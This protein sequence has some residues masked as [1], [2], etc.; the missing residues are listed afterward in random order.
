[1]NKIT[2][3]TSVRA[4]I[5]WVWIIK[6]KQTS[7]IQRVTQTFSIQQKPTNDWNVPIYKYICVLCEITVINNKFE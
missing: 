3:L 4:A 7:G 6:R 5:A 1:M 2:A